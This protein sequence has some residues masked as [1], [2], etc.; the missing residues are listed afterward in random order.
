MGM[1]VSRSWLLGVAATGLLAISAWPASAAD[2]EGLNLALHPGGVG[3]FEENWLVKDGKL[4]EFVTAYRKEVYSLARRAPGYRG[5]IVWTTMP[6]EPGD[7]ATPE[8]FATRRYKFISPHPS[9]YLNG[10]IRTERLVNVGA[11][12]GQTYNVRIVHY[13]Q[14]W[15]DAA[16]FHKAMEKTYADAHEGASLA[17]HLSKTV[18]PLTDN[19]WTA[20]YR[21]VQ[22]GYD[23]SAYPAKGTAK[24]SGGL[25][26]EPHA[27]PLNITEEGWDV[28]PGQLDSF[29]KNYERDVYSV[30][31]RIKGYRGYTVVTTI[32]PA[33]NEPKPALPLG[34]PE[35]F[36]VPYPGLMM[37]GDVRTDT[38]INAGAMFRK[39][40]NVKVYH[41]L[42]DWVTGKNWVADYKTIYQKEH[43]GEDPWKYLEKTM[44]QKVKNHWDYALRGVEMSFTP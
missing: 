11:V 39:V 21:M 36:T 27:G 41:M 37:Y 44:F 12:M 16:G 19:V 43:N 6:P 14:T 38:S 15:K 25:N 8:S 23:P 4:T 29:L 42:D 40:Y 18:Y 3:W 35:A 30:L 13:L 7:T 10:T 9:I 28:L 31:R 32:A 1:T 24:D 34:S 17:D 2:T 26:L 5:Y 33:A 22:T 20:Q